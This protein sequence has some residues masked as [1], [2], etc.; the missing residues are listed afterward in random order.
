MSDFF[1]EQKNRKPPDID[2]LANEQ[3]RKQII[4]FVVEEFLGR[5]LRGIFY[6]YVNY[7]MPSYQ[8]LKCLI[9]DRSNKY[10]RTS[11]PRSCPYIQSFYEIQLIQPC[12]DRITYV[13]F[14]FYIIEKILIRI[15]NKLLYRRIRI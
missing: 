10:G 12:I 1:E 11:R 3:L 4:N 6:L 2:L 13:T 8:A 7:Q 9:V 5:V 15:S 14:F